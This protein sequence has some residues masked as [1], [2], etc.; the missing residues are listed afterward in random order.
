MPV[1]DDEGALAQADTVHR[2]WESAD[3]H[4]Q[5]GHEECRKKVDV[6]ADRADHKV[7]EQCQKAVEEQ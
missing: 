2:E 7:L 3:H 5:R 1:K 6:P 4:D